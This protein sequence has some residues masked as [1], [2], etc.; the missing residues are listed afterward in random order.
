[1]NFLD[2]A[3]NRYTA[4]EYNSEKRVSDEDIAKLKEI[5]RLSPSSINSQPWN[6]IFISDNKVKTKLAAASSWN[7]QR[8]NDASHLVVFTAI[9][10]I[11]NF[12]QQLNAN[13]REGTVIKYYNRYVKPT[14][15]ENIKSW[16]QHQVYLS[17]GYFLSAC[18]TMS[19]DSTAMEGIQNEEY[20]KILELD[21]YKTLFAVAIGYRNPNDENQPNITPKSRLP[22]EKVIKS[23]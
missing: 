10:N 18:A 16:M 12:E 8:I 3:Q 5:L 22:L 17:L 7:E 14:G 21:G 20:D 2:I 15:D 11:E 13:L 6:F 4:K 9:D 19:I 1:M 23:I